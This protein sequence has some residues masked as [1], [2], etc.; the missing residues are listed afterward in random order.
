MM[1]T[2]HMGASL[3]GIL[4][5][6]RGPPGTDVVVVVGAGIVGA[7][8]AHHAARAGVSVLLI[9]RSRPA[10][11]VTGDSF[12]WV[13]GASAQAAMDGKAQ[14]SCSASPMMMPS[15]P[16]RKQSR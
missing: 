7:S 11:G 9:D 3:S 8:V 6:V 13:R 15:G 12:A 1:I 2:G 5:R 14:L 16:R 4:S 10:S